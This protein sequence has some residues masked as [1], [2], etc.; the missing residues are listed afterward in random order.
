[1]ALVFPPGT[2]SGIDG[3]DVVVFNEDDREIAR[4]GQFVV[5]GGEADAGVSSCLDASEANAPWLVSAVDDV[6]APDEVTE[7]IECP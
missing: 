1:M 3:E 6:C 2:T 7:D 5:V 4:T